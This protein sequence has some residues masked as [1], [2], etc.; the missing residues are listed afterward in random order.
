MPMKSKL[1]AK[2]ANFYLSR[3]DKQER[4]VM[5][6]LNTKSKN[7]SD[8][9]M[10]PASPF[11][12]EKIV[13]GLKVKQY[14]YTWRHTDPDFSIVSSGIGAPSAA[15]IIETLRKAG[16]K[17]IVRIDFAGSLNPNIKSGDFFIPIKAIKGDG[18]S[19]IYSGNG[20]PYAYP[21]SNL[22]EKIEVALKDMHLVYH[23]GT[24]YTHD[25]IFKE[26]KEYIN[27]MISKGADAVDMETALLY[28]LGALYGLETCAV[29]IISNPAT[30][31]FEEEV[32]SI[33]PEFFD[34][35]NKSIK[36]IPKI[37]SILR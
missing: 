2:I 28:T 29:L 14:G 8:L 26:D 1:Y 11:Y 20:D 12:V 7:I 27:Q 19:K 18:T 5:I 21:N 15:Y 13:S 34:A 22:C 36:L 35:I 10:L 31:G 25:A 16:V 37:A 30:E 9:V 6:G 23:K 24:I 4:L 3:L 32:S 33:T 17:T